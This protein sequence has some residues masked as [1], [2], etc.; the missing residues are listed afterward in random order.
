MAKQNQYFPSIV[1]HPGE[2]LAE[3][4]YEM[5]MGLNEFALRSGKPEKTI[6]AILRGQSSITPDMAVQ[7][8]DVTKIPANFWLNHQRSYDE[9]VARKKHLRVIEA[10]VPWA[11]KFPYTS[12]VN[13]GWLS[14]E[15]DPAAIAK[16]MLAFFSF[17]NHMVWEKY[18]VKRLLKVTFR[19]S[20]EQ[21]SDPYAISAWLRQGELQAAACASKV[22]SP[23]KLRDVLPKLKSLMCTNPPDLFTQLQAIC[24]RAGITLIHT[25]SLENVPILGA[26]RWLH[27]VPLIQ[28]ASYY[29]RND[30]FWFTFFHELGHILY[31]GKKDIFL[32]QVTYA[33]ID[34]MKE[35]EADA[36]ATSWILSDADESAI[37]EMADFSHASI[38]ACA[39]KYNTN[40]AIIV[41]RLQQKKLVS[42]AFASKYIQAIRFRQEVK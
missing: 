31:H 26:T 30:V 40:P 5:D 11:Q 12:M 35:D 8:E 18:Y 16:A 13:H 25:P 10:A 6:I 33:D 24:L 36:F 21:M 3:K 38:A 23:K 37:I 32:E 14:A 20:L 1:F 28:L 41:G 2:T 34:Q 4:L 17:S 42:D 9:F 7:F 27:Q 15:E 29:A 19:I 39:E 22:Y